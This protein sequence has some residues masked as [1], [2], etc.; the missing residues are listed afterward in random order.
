[1]AKRSAILNN[2]LSKP[3]TTLE[4]E[5]ALAK[6][7]DVR[8]NIIVP[9]ISWGL[10]SHEVDLLVVRKSGIAVEVEIKISVQD[11]KADFKKSHHH[12][13]KQNR[14]TEFYYAMPKDIYEKCID[15]IPKSA[16]IIICERYINY[17]K[18]SAV[19]ATLLRKSTRIKGSRKLTSEEQFKVAKLGC[20]RIFSLK[21]KIVKSKTKQD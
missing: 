19:K 14:I 18:E 8:R 3:L 16:G 11:L 13:E 5:I 1:M 21:E 2:L 12:I 15:I 10:L 7:F 20:M 6:Y 4:L 17:K 9:N